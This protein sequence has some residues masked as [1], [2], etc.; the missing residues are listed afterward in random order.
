MMKSG[1]KSIVIMLKFA[2]CRFSLNYEESEIISFK[3][4]NNIDAPQNISVIN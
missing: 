1:E 4:I 2:Y 3:T